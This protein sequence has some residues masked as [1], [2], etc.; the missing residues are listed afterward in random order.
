MS[1]GKEARQNSRKFET[2]GGP[3]GQGCCFVEKIGV[4]LDDCREATPDISQARSA[5]FG[6]KG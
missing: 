6:V 3:R 5:W 2:R 4:E 1:A